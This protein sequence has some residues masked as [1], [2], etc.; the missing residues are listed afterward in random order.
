MKKFILFLI[1]I[2]F[3]SAS[4]IKILMLTDFYPNNKT[5]NRAVDDA[6]NTLAIKYELSNDNFEHINLSLKDISEFNNN[7]IIL[8]RYLKKYKEKLVYI[9]TV[10]DTKQ[11]LTNIEL[12]DKGLGDILSDIPILCGLG[13]KSRLLELAAGEYKAKIFTTSSLSNTKAKALYNLVRSEK[14]TH[15]INVGDKQNCDENILNDDE[16]INEQLM[17]LKKLVK[18][19]KS[20]KFNSLYFHSNCNDTA[21]IKPKQINA[22]LE[23]KNNNV[24]FMFGEYTSKQT[25]AL[26]DNF[27]W[28]IRIL[29]YLN[30]YKNFSAYLLNVSDIEKNSFKENYPI[31][32]N[33]FDLHTNKSSSNIYNMTYNK[34]VTQLDIVLNSIKHEF[35]KDPKIKIPHFRKKIL[36]SMINTTKK[37]PY[38]NNDTNS[39]IMFKEHNGYYY[40]NIY[41]DNLYLMYLT[42]IDNMHQRLDNRQYYLNQEDINNTIPVLY[43]DF[44][45]KN[46]V[47][48]GLGASSA[49]VEVLVR[50][51]SSSDIN[52][53]DVVSFNSI[54]NST[55]NSETQ[56]Q[57][58]EVLHNSDGSIF[59]KKTFSVKDSFSI[60]S[61]LMKFPFDKQNIEIRL[62]PEYDKGSGMRPIIQVFTIDK[63][64]E[65]GNW[66]MN[67][68]LLSNRKDFI[69]FPESMLTHDVS[70]EVHPTNI[71][72]I[73]IERTGKY[74]VVLKYTIPMFMFVILMLY[75]FFRLY[76][77]ITQDGET[78][79]FLNTMMGIMY[80]YFIFSL[81]ININEIIWFDIFFFGMLGL[82]VLLLIININRYNAN[83]D[84]HY[85]VW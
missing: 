60:D 58:S 12:L 64:E 67:S 44:D 6:I 26:F 62:Q 74:L 36:N 10:D 22:L 65:F 43:V 2:S 5:Q 57:T 45:V 66:K 51:V 23:N 77:K 14:F 53:Q 7:K 55:Y 28:R 63:Q 78:D 49:Y 84:K 30:K 4:D 85:S 25:R 21:T 19:D 70:L 37:S 83:Y 72:E 79:I 52:F 8:E 18:D 81:L 24:L 40:N 15:L 56:M 9:W 17:Y 48:N 3:T 75:T 31:Y 69:V 50:T 76:Y 47:V 61:D 68:M 16:Y 80:V 33:E 38:F 13:T 27:S 71:I 59:Y 54:K 35:N 39:V 46:I 34:F 82:V 73:E 32:F 1:F 29:R 42:R 20:V 11:V 41:E